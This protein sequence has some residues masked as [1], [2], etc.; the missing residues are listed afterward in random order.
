MRNPWCMVFDDH[1]QKSD[2]GY[3]R[4]PLAY[5]KQLARHAVFQ[6]RRSVQTVKVVS[7]HTE[8]STRLRISH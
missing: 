7:T 5:F 1:A 2:Y 4:A 6:H 8:T 3:K